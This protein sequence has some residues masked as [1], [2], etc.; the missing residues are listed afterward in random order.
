MN[1]LANDGISPSGLAA[2]KEAGHNVYTDFIDAD[3]LESFINENSIDGL[4]VRSA[5]KVRQP[6]MDA[7][8]T[9]KFVG[10]GGVGMD[11]IDVEYYRS[12]GI[13]VFNTP[14]AS[15]QSVAE[16][17]MGSLFSLTRSLHTSNRKM[18]SE[19]ASNFKALKKAYGKGTELRG[20]TLGIVGFGRI[21]RAL[22]SY[23]LGCGMKVI[24]HDMNLGATSV[25]LDIAV[26]KFKCRCT[27]ATD[28]R[29]T[30]S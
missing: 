2:L 28:G 6:L 23:A 9:L 4:L 24:A 21:G 7:C 29:S 15:S 27:S 17:V 19:G 3:N 14:A 5:T 20:K 16:L 10:R 22:A 30:R 13:N 25:D 18:P 1:I 12:K 8:P 26:Y 11:N